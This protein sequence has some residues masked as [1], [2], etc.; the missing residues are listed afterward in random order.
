MLHRVHVPCHTYIR[1]IQ[2]V[3]NRLKASEFCTLC[4]IRIFTTFM[5]ITRTI[6][7]IR[8]A[9]CFSVPVLVL[10]A[11]AAVVVILLFGNS[12]ARPVLLN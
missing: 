8:L 4:I 1:Q 5:C 9:D 3:H 2:M 12:P 6:S 11:A 7:F 10:K